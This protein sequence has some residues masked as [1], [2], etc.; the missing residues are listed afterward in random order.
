MRNAELRF[1]THQLTAQIAADRRE[2]E[3]GE[4]ALARL[5]D[6]ERGLDAA[7]ASLNDP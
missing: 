4:R 5:I 7:N 1:S 3:E 6:E 2:V